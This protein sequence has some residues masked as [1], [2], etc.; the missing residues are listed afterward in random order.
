MITHLQMMEAVLQDNLYNHPNK[1]HK[2]G[3]LLQTQPRALR[4]S[5]DAE[6][7]VGHPRQIQPQGIDPLL[8]NCRRSLNPNRA[9][10]FQ[11][12]QALE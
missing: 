3:C 11:I 10:Y 2:I 12:E 9:Y 4:A 1:S 8:T 6:E 5:Y 7:D